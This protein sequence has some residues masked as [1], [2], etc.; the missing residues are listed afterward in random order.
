MLLNYGKASA[1]SSETTWTRP[2]LSANGTLGGN[3]FAV[4]STTHYSSYYTWHAFNGSTT[5]NTSNLFRVNSNNMYVT[6]YNPDPIR[7]IS[8]NCYTYTVANTVPTAGNFYGSNDNSS[9]TNIKAWTNSNCVANSYWTLTINSSQYYKY[10]KLVVTSTN[11]S[12]QTD[13]CEIQINAKI[14]TS[15]AL[16]NINFPISHTNSSSYSPYL[17][18]YNGTGN[19]YISSKTKSNISL[20]NSS[21]ATSIYYGTIGY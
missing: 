13:F 9:W 16:N 19:C 11:G 8:L 20:S 2:N 4:D 14:M 3:S 17:C 18:L 15:G 12:S 21:S 5:A 10:H 6:F 1:S 7:V